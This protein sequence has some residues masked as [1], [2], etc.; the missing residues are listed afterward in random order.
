MVLASAIGF[1]SPWIDSVHLATCVIALERHCR[2][3][4]F[5][6][7]VSINM[8]LKTW[9]IA[10][11]VLMLM[12]NSHSLP[13]A[14]AWSSTSVLAEVWSSVEVGVRLV[15]RGLCNVPLFYRQFPSVRGGFINH[16]KCRNRESSPIG[17]LIWILTFSLLIYIQ[18]RYLGNP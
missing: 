18:L 1:Y 6:G 8:S 14:L 17:V 13:G 9:L 16:R 11:A 15:C 7:T 2:G 3:F 5:Q 10:F 4:P 12:L